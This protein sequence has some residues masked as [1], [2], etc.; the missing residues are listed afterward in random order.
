MKSL[1][2]FLFLS[3][4]IFFFL[5]NLVQASG[6]AFEGSMEQVN[7]FGYTE[8]NLSG[9]SPN[10]APQSPSLVPDSKDLYIEDLDRIRLLNADIEKLERELQTNP[11]YEK[12]KSYLGEEM[13]IEN[14]E[15]L[16]TRMCG[17]IAFIFSWPHKEGAPIA[18]AFFK[19]EAN[20][21]PYEITYEKNIRIF[22]RAFTTMKLKLFLD[23]VNAIVRSDR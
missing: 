17:Y 9:N 13:P 3:V 18:P 4:G 14:D 21:I 1:S 16:A 20:R 7:S 10:W 12:F 2:I 11:L 6:E 22:F 8:S 19:A 15:E 23:E 5:E